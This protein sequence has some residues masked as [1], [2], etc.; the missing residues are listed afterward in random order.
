M[1]K[2][3]AGDA[4]IFNPTRV[5]A[6]PQGTPVPAD[7][8]DASA[9]PQGYPHKVWTDSGGSM[10]GVVIIEGGCSRGSVEIDEQS[11][12]RVALTL[13]DT[14]PIYSEP[15]GCSADSRHL[16]HGVSLDKPLGDRTVALKSER[17]TVHERR[18]TG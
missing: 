16:E 8:V 13:A 18:A 6:P 12:S 7:Q 15:G 1:R 9:L 4:P 14:T 11:A 10:L 2:S 3:S 17:R 5:T